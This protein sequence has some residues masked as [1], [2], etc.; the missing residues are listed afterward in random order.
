MLVKHLVVVAMIVI[1]FWFNAIK[2]V[3]QDLRSYPNDPQ[4]MARFRRYINVMTICGVL[5]LASGLLLRLSIIGCTLKS[6][7][8]VHNADA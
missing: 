7:E 4:R 5:V 3:G 6:N 2:R 8:F 1:G